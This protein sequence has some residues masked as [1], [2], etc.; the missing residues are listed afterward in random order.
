MAKKKFKK[1]KKGIMRNY[2]IKPR[3]IRIGHRM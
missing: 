2:R 3:K 1:K